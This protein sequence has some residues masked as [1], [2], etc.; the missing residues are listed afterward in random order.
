MWA[1]EYPDDM[2]FNIIANSSYK[3]S[4]YRYVMI[5]GIKSIIENNA[6]FNCESYNES[7]SNI[8]I[9]VYQLIFSMYFSQKIFHEM[10]NDEIDVFMEQF[11]DKSYSIDIHDF[12]FQYDALLDY[13]LED[14]L[15]NIKSEV[16]VIIPEDNFYFSSEKDVDVLNG[17]IK[18]CQTEVVDFKRNKY[19]EMDFRDVL[20][21]LDTFLKKF[22]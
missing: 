10:S 1:C 16:L 14:K 12:K 3:T 6:D 8:M 18:N 13:N 2:K 9:S 15:N 11:I 22:K 7:F 20:I 17:M 21:I 19:D 5:K 4:G